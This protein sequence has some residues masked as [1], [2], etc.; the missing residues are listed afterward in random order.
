MRPEWAGRTHLAQRVIDAFFVRTAVDR[1]QHRKASDRFPA[2]DLNPGV[3]QRKVVTKIG[4]GRFSEPFVQLNLGV[5][6]NKNA[7]HGL[8]GFLVVGSIEGQ[9]GEWV[10]PAPAFS[11]FP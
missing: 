11:H 4:L 10:I 8:R 3:L 6:R 7:Q 9:C 5:L 1:L 2:H